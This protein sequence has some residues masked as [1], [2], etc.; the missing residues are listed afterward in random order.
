MGESHE[1]NLGGL[2]GWSGTG[3]GFG[4]GFT[5][6]WRGYLGLDLQVHDLSHTLEGDFKDPL[7]YEFSLEAHAPK[8]HVP[9]MLKAALPGHTVRPSLSVGISYT[10]SQASRHDIKANGQL[11][12]VVSFGIMSDEQIVPRFGLGVDYTLP[13]EGQNVRVSLSVMTNYN[14]DVAD[15]LEADTLS[16][17]C[18]M[19]DPTNSKPAN[20]AADFEDNVV[21]QTDIMVGI[22]YYF[23]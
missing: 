12:E 3:G 21:W 17:V 9:V 18:G 2:P 16:S 14:G 15:R 1:G 10:A 23:P 11:P 22:G 6:M 7:G 20:C 4:M 5:A 8:I 19:A 13:I